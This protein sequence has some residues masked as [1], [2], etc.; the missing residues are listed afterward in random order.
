MRSVGLDN[1]RRLLWLLAAIFVVGCSQAPTVNPTETPV[2]RATF[3]RVMNIDGPPVD[4]VINNV[5][6]ETLA[7]NTGG[8]YEPGLGKTPALP[9]EVALITSAG[10]ELRRFSMTDATGDVGAM[11]LSGGVTL[12]SSVMGGPEEPCP[13]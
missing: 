2:A 1:I 9:W 5:R 6:V 3:L 10:D 4:V 8:R 11:I 12:G 13:T 7:C